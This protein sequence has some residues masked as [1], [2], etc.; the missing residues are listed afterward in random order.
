[1][2]TSPN[3]YIALPALLL[4]LLVASCTKVITLNLGND[5]GKLVIEGNITNN[6]GPQIIKLSQNVA[7]SNTNTYPPVSGA[8]VY[9]TDGKGN[10]YNFTEAPAGTYTCG[11][12]IGTPGTTYNMSVSTGGSTYTAT[13]VMPG[14]V[15]LDSITSRP[16]ILNTTNNRQQI[17]VHFQDPAGVVNQYLFLMYVNGVQVN[18]IFP[19]NDDFTD[20][21]YVNLDIR[22]SD[23]DVHPLDTVKMT[24]QC[25]DKTNYTY[26][27]TLA[28]QQT[29]GPGGGV[30][31]D[32]PPNNI[33]PTVLGYFSAHTTQNL[34]LVVK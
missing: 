21:R 10:K 22:E 3:K 26:W 11:S 33:T 29:N 14:V 31:P 32:N 7:F 30:T 34:T 6:P 1:M 25:I 19:L 8:V 5:T 20:G 23:I 2:K 16:A 15:L 12:L 13:S 28:Q 4:L 9:V 27:R 17:T 18:S 24:M